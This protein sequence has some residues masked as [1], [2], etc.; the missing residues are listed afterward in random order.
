MAGPTWVRLDTAYFT[1]PKILRAGPNGALLHL[2]A[3][4]YLG[5]HE[6]DDGVLPAEALDLVA[7]MVK[8]RKPDAVVDRLVAAG[9]WHEQPGGWQVHHYDVM[10]GA[11]SDAAAARRRQRAKRERDRDRGV[12]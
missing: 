4:C 10:N 9:L 12:T 7:G 6:L 11:S 3:I 2:A 5:G 8:V 1:N